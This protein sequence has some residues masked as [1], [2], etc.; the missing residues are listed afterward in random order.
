MYVDRKDSTDTYFLL[1]R[2][3]IG[4]DRITWR[5]TVIVADPKAPQKKTAT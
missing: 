1:R 5:A 2:V 4:S 3:R